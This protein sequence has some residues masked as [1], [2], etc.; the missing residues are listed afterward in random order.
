M[1]RP[2]I[3]VKAVDTLLFSRVGVPVFHPYRVFDRHGTHA[4]FR[5]TYMRRMHTFLEESDAASLRRR[6]G[7]HAHDIAARLSRTSPRREEDKS[8]DVSSRPMVYR[9]LPGSGVYRVG[10]SGVLIE[11]RGSGSLSSYGG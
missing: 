1:T 3:S 2:I 7:R 4:A 9:S 6:H 11:G 10:D 8:P 5:G